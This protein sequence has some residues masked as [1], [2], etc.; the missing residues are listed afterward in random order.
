MKPTPTPSLS[1]LDLLIIKGW[2]K[3][4]DGFLM[5]QKKSRQASTLQEQESLLFES[6]RD[7]VTGLEV[8]SETLPDAFQRMGSSRRLP[9]TSSLPSGLDTIVSAIRGD[10]DPIAWRIM[11]PQHRDSAIELV[12]HVGHN[13]PVIVWDESQC[14]TTHFV[15]EEKQLKAA[16]DSISFA[17][18]DDWMLVKPDLHMNL[19]CSVTERFLIGWRRNISGQ[20]GASSGMTLT[21]VNPYQLQED[22]LPKAEQYVKSNQGKWQGLNKVARAVGVA[23]NTLGKWLDKSASLIP[24]E[25]T[26]NGVKRWARTPEVQWAVEKSATYLRARR[27]R[28]EQ[29][30]T[31]TNPLDHAPQELEPDESGQRALDGFLIAPSDDQEAKEETEWM[32]KN[33][34]PML[35]IR[36]HLR[37]L[38]SVQALLS[39]NCDLT[40]D[41]IVRKI[42]S[43]GDL[44]DKAYAQA[45]E[46]E[47]KN[48]ASLRK[49]D[50]SKARREIE[51][52][53]KEQQIDQKSRSSRENKRRGGG[54][55]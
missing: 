2:L 54:R 10:K 29:E 46:V 49:Q 5:N 30:S 21:K 39:K 31:G 26:K 41:E 42:T 53:C 47:E 55:G 36:K 34:Q 14:R 43:D 38:P 37:Q 44:F 27:A 45:Q 40:D 15:P 6:D 22:K 23:P 9:E 4:L 32:R 35:L 20:A 7:I 1:K 25:P 52:L 48:A 28:A 33:K 50:P 24:P 3:R 11:D 8:L 51:Q 16:S 19:I 13:G 12:I 17:H 18:P